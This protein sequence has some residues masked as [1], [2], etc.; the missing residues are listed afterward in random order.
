MKTEGRDK[1]I[2]NL[3]RLRI[4]DEK[5]FTSVH[6]LAGLRNAVLVN[7]GYRLLRRLYE[8]HLRH[9]FISFQ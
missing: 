7:V 1:W 8:I 6:E 2:K 3:R 5:V 9:S 4:Q